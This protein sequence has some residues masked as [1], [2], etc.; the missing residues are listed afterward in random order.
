MRSR[1]GIRPHQM[2]GRIF[3][4]RDRES[5]RLARPILGQYRQPRALQFIQTSPGGR[6]ASDPHIVHRYVTDDGGTSS[7]LRRC[8]VRRRQGLDPAQGV[9]LL[10]I[11]AGFEPSRREGHEHPVWVGRPLGTLL[12][13]PVGR[14]H[15]PPVQVP[16]AE[17]E[18]QSP[19]VSGALANSW[20]RRTNSTSS[21][22]GVNSTSFSHGSPAALASVIASCNRP[23]AP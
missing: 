18:H 16:D 22:D 3:G 13:R 5:A 7:E 19:P 14:R 23:S 15:R 1:V 12:A 8:D 11:F 20:L 2:H 17:G 10:G 6:P 21:G 4:D 9:C